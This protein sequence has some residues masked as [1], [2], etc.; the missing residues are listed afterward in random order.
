MASAAE[1]LAKVLEDLGLEKGAD[2]TEIAK[3]IAAR[4]SKARAEASQR[5]A[6]AKWTPYINQDG[7]CRFSGSQLSIASDELEGLKTLLTGEDFATFWAANTAAIKTRAEIV[8][9]RNAR[10]K[11]NKA[12]GAPATGAVGGATP[13]AA[14]AAP[15]AP[16]TPPAAPAAPATPPA[17][18][19][20]ARTKRGPEG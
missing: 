17:A 2:A 15:A 7:A 1:T 3:A 4:E 13:P 12:A 14:P 9:T 5:V 19:A 16:A 20:K 11:A 6:M 8:K 10:R 18:P